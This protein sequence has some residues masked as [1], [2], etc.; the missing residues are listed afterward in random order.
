MGKSISIES[1]RQEA[2]RARNSESAE[3]LFR[4][5]R[6][7]QWV[8]LKKTGWLPLTLWDTTQAAWSTSDMVGYRCYGGLDLSSTTDLTA[9]CL[10][11]PP[12]RDSKEW[13][14]IFEVWIPQDNIKERVERDHAPYDRWAKEKYL[15]TTP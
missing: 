9:L 10:L 2:L 12:Q 4:W 3:K 15:H 7:N 6:L 8:S 11:F 5:L 13:R 1:V 14:A